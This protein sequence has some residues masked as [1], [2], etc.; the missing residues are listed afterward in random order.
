MFFS[1][2]KILDIPQVDIS[3][4]DIDTTDIININ[5]II[6]EDDNIDMKIDDYGYIKLSNDNKDV[7]EDEVNQ[8]DDKIL[9]KEEENNDELLDDEEDEDEE[10][11]NDDELCDEEDC[12]FIISV[13]GVPSYY[14]EKIINAKNT[15]DNV[16]KLYSLNEYGYHDIHIKYISDT[17]ID[18]IRNYDFWFFSINYVMHKFKIFKIIKSQ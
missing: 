1:S 14:E 6:K 15:I 2:K 17:E 12:L 11:E 7:N 10:E 18:I 3:Y 5:Y 8:N 9:D 13:D 16:S 4:K